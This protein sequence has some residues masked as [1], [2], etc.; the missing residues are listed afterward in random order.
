[1]PLIPKASLPDWQGNGLIFLLLI[2]LIKRLKLQIGCNNTLFFSSSCKLVK[3][4]QI[5]YFFYFATSLPCRQA[6]L[7]CSAYQ[8]FMI[9]PRTGLLQAGFHKDFLDNP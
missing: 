8:C 4:L 5:D 2:Q 1:L 6:G 3:K 7:R 9:I